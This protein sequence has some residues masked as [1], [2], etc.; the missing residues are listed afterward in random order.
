[1][2]FAVYDPQ[3]P[4]SYFTSWRAATGQPGGFNYIFAPKNERYRCS[5]LRHSV[6]AR[7]RRD[8]WS[9]GGCVRRGIGDHEDLYR[10]PGAAPATLTPLRPNGALPS[11]DALGTATAVNH[12]D[13]SSWKFHMKSAT[14]QVLRLHLTDVPG[15]HASI[16]GQPLNL[17]RFSG[18]MLQA[19]IPAGRHT[20][21]LH[22]WPDAFSY[23]LA[24][25]ACG[26]IGLASALIIV[27][28]RCRTRRGRLSVGGTLQT[29]P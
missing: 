16:D 5:S 28:I 6:C 14:A 22:Y 9:P 11:T 25:A 12:P 15:W 10:I 17:E 23:G 24:L 1:M 29:S 2:N 4:Y 8:L 26:V 18:T 3:V 27:I 19:R 13:P 7:T 20:I 21:D